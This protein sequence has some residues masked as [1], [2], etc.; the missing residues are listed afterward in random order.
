MKVKV[1]VVA[2]K[3][4]ERERE[5]SD[6]FEWLI[7]WMNEWVIHCEFLRLRLSEWVS[8]HQNHIINK[9]KAPTR[10]CAS[11]VL[12]SNSWKQNKTKHSCNHADKTTTSLSL[13]LSTDSYFFF[14]FFPI[15]SFPIFI[16]YFTPQSIDQAPYCTLFHR[17]SPNPFSSPPV[18]LILCILIYKLFKL[19]AVQASGIWSCLRIRFI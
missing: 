5:S 17:P 14:F 16:F 8:E 6:W 10:A 1:I 19:L 7:E 4:G 18:I 12:H 11:G 15:Y 13:S 3:E 2:A 9:R